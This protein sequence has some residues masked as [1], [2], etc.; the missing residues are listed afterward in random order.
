MTF[1]ESRM[2]SEL[3]WQCYIDPT[4]GHAEL[5]TSVYSMPLRYASGSHGIR[6]WAE[7]GG[8]V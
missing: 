8:H 4:F 7:A 6:H 1:I 5:I 3:S 2:T